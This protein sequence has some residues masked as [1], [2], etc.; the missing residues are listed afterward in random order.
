MGFD[1]MPLVD[2]LAVEGLSGLLYLKVLM[3]FLMILPLHNAEN[4]LVRD[5][6]V[7]QRVSEERMSNCSHVGFQYVCYV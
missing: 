7:L 5:I 2:H 4:G 1:V 6:L 3:V